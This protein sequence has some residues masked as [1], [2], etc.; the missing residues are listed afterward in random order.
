MLEKVERITIDKVVA[1]SLKSWILENDLQPGDRLP[2]E[3][4][5]SEELGVARHTLREGVKRLSQLGIV[6]SRVGSGLYISEVNFD[7]VAEYMLFLKRRGYISLKDIYS[8]RTTLECGVAREAAVQIDGAHIAL[9]RDRIA[10]MDQCCENDDFK[11]YVL[12][13]ISFHMELAD[14]TGNHLF[15]GIISA[16]RQVFADHMSSLDSATAHNSQHQHKEILEAVISHDPDLAEQKM[17]KH[18]GDISPSF[19]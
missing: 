11:S 18:L 6:G 4:Q 19:Y 13:D 3:Q 17:K 15:S 14:S 1:E 5:L 7:N 12:Q 10:K 8:V 9:L 2:S 16:L